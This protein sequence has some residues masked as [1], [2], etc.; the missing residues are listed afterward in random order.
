[1]AVKNP[2]S[3]S[4]RDCRWIVSTER[5]DLL[6]CQGLSTALNTVKRAAHSLMPARESYS[7]HSNV[8][9]PSN[10]PSPRCQERKGRSPVPDI[11]LSEVQLVASQ[12]GWEIEQD[13]ERYYLRTREPETFHKAPLSDLPDQRTICRFSARLPSCSTSSP[14]N[15]LFSLAAH[16]TLIAP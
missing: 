10:F 8:I 4:P 3:I 15:D 9:F 5:E 1:M 6:A 14:E 13:G 12:Y 2:Y 7:D 16:W 11:S